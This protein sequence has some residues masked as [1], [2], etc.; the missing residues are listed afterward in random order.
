[1]ATSEKTT[2]VASAARTVSGT[3]IAAEQSLGLYSRATVLLDV[4]VAAAA[5]GDTLDVYIQKNVASEGTPVWTDFVHFTQVLGNGGAKQFVAEV[6]ATI[7]PT[8]A[9]H[10]VQDAAL[11]AGVNQGPWSDR[12][13]VKWVIAGATQS[14]TFSVEA[15][16]QGPD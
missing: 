16:L 13:R 2:L 1:M 15:V 11:A 8:A 6:Q 5:A 9:L 10:V 7:A 3:A 14:F 4:T 12:W